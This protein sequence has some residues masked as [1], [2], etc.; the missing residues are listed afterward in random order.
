[1]NGMQQYLFKL[2][3]MYC[4][5]HIIEKM[6]FRCPSEDGKHWLY[7]LGLREETRAEETNLET[8]ST[9]MVF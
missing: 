7:E 9:L 2:V 8:I 3:S 6:P 4:F 5:G 1:M